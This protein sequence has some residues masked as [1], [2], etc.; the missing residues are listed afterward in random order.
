VPAIGCHRAVAGHL[1]QRLGTGPD[2]VEAVEAQQVHVRARVA[3]PQHAIDVESVG[4]GCHLETLADH[5]LIGL[6]GLDLLLGAVDRPRVLG[7][8]RRRS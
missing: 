6:A 7:R 4:L 8:S 3:D 1:H 5:D 2:H